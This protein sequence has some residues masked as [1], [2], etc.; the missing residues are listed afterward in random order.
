MQQVND[1]QYYSFHN[2]QYKIKIY[3]EETFLFDNLCILKCFFFKYTENDLKCLFNYL[4]FI[5][6]ILSLSLCNR[7]RKLM[8]YSLF[9]YIYILCAIEIINF[10]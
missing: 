3:N 7:N 5:S 9:S 4:Y 1:K 2:L 6:Y 10:I 8:L